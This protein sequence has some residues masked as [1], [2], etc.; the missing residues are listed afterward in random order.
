MVAKRGQSAAADC[1]SGAVLVGL[2]LNYERRL[3]ADSSSDEVVGRFEHREFE[4]LEMED[5]GAG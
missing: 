2:H 5:L 1:G 3:F 4:H